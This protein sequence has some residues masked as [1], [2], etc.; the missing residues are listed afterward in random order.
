M[1][2]L[3]WDSA[4]PQLAFEQ[5]A[6]DLP[7]LGAL[8]REGTW[9]A[10]RSCIP[11][12]TV[13]AWA[14]MLSGRDPG[15]LGVYGFR[16]R[17]RGDYLQQRL[18][19]SRSIR[20]PRV[21]DLLGAAGRDCLVL[22]LPQTWPVQ[23]MRGH[24]L[25][26]PL[27]PGPGSA[28]A[29]PAIF[30]QEVL[31]REPGYRFDLRDFR[32]LD[33]A[34]VLQA[35]IDMAEMQHRL[36]CHCLRTKPWDFALQ[37]HMG[38]DRAQHLFWSDHDPQH[39]AHVPGGRWRHALRD[40]YRMLD[41]MAGELLE[42]AGE[43]CDVL[44]V[45][46]HGAQRMDGGICVNEWLWRAG[47]LRLRRE[48]PAGRLSGLADLEVDWSRTR[49]WADGGYCGRVW[50]NLA[51]REPQGCVTPQEAPVLLDELTAGLRAIRGPQGQAL[52]TQVY[53]PRAIYR[54]VRGLAPDL[55]LHFGDLRWRALGTLGHGRDWSLENDRGVDG[56]NHAMAGLF[57]LREARRR[58][59]GELRG[60]QL[61]DVAPTVLK[62]LRVARPVG[63]QG[64]PL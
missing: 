10:L 19:D 5:F 63:M 51:G 2:L 25:S 40:F 55:L 56:A 9:G 62:R 6:P 43:D 28:C 7:V 36:L 3:G 44:I 13:P 16:R 21:H 38:L 18:A 47:W 26:G 60:R 24:L 22:G 45:S 42:L 8:R 32:A 15:E 34:Q 54:E 64:D 41:T 4:A 12:I 17:R 27:T 48:P 30:R 1:L 59:R 57:V 20:R 35:L 33:K 49:A 23:P 29:W 14:S 53:R 39:R 50:L 61:M 52:S 46:D 11:C 37:V 31:Q 58:G